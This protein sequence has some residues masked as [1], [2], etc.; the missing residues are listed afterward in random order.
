[1]AV[2]ALVDPHTPLELPV[3]ILGAIDSRALLNTSETLSF[4]IPIRNSECYFSKLG[5]WYL[6]L[7][8][9]IG[10]RSTRLSTKFDVKISVRIEFY[11]FVY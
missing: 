11:P 9:P 4:Q 6:D 8:P 3:L 1:M 10:D 7:K 2:G 5:S